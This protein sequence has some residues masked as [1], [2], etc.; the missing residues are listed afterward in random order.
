MCSVHILYSLIKQ[1]WRIGGS[2]LLKTNFILLIGQFV[3]HS[4]TALFFWQICL[5]YN[6]MAVRLC[7]PLLFN[8]K[9]KPVQSFKVR[10]PIKG[11]H[12]FQ[13]QEL[14]PHCSVLLVFRNS[15]KHD[16]HK[17]NWVILTFYFNFEWIVM[18]IYI[19]NITV[20]TFMELSP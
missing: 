13:E 4:A 3:I 12:C 18:Y 1:I 11:S 7:S 10:N 17:Q 14:Y 16:F 19:K 15:F 2:I 8:D 5:Y 20:A 9:Y 6:S